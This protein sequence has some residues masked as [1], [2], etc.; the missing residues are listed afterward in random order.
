MKTTF[1]KI[2]ALLCFILLDVNLYGQAQQ[3]GRAS[4]TGINEK[5]SIKIV[6][7]SSSLATQLLFSG[8]GIALFKDAHPT[9]EEAQAA[10]ACKPASGVS[11]SRCGT[12]TVPAN[13]PYSRLGRGGW[14]YYNYT[15]ET[16]QCLPGSWTGTLRDSTGNLI[17]EPWYVAP[18]KTYNYCLSVT[19]S[20][21]ACTATSFCLNPYAV[22][23]KYDLEHYYKKDNTTKF[24]HKLP[25]NSLLFSRDYMAVSA[26]GSNVSEFRIT[27][28]P[29]QNSLNWKLRIKEDP[30]GANA[31]KYGTFAFVSNMTAGIKFNYTHPTIPPSATNKPYEEY[32]IELI[33]AANANIVVKVFKIRVYRAPLLMVHGLNSGPSSFDTMYINFSN[34]NLYIKDNMLKVDYEGENEYTFTANNSV[35]P[36]A[37]EEIT[38]NMLKMKIAVK[39]VD[40]VG[41]SMGGILSRLYHQSSTYKS[42]VNRIITICTPHAG[43][44]LGDLINDPNFPGYS[45]GAVCWWLDC[46]EAI[47]NLRVG[48]AEQNTVIDT[49]LNGATRLSNPVPSHAIITTQTLA[50][51]SKDMKRIWKYLGTTPN[52][53]FGEASDLIVPLSSQQGGLLNNYITS[54]EGQE[55]AGAHANINIINRVAALLAM[56]PNVSLFNKSGFN[57]PNLIYTPLPPSL[58]STLMATSPPPVIIINPLN[59]KTINRNS[60]INISATCQ[61]APKMFL[62]VKRTKNDVLSYEVNASAISIN[63]SIDASFPIGEHKFLVE[64]EFA[65]GQFS[66]AEGKFTVTNCVDNYNPLVGEITNPYYQAKNKIVASGQLVFGQPV[67]MTAGQSIEFKPGFVADT[68]TTLEAKIKACDN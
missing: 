18:G 41:H 63:I 17:P 11:T 19:L 53:L 31:A 12:F 1:F 54:I 43:S 46:D 60:Q 33:D 22:E 23:V 37:I 65:D 64:A 52:A 14:L 39:K 48:A 38:G 44:H 36:D 10:N 55:H 28:Q 34:K 62:Y 5:D 3:P 29:A 27:G 49:G 4:V 40:L 7:E 24:L 68:Y 16:N 35:I 21:G 30:T 61:Q 51:G 56:D 20:N 57:P 26:D 42:D 25:D 50:N 66:Y 47:D 15:S 13:Q 32:N 58:Q 6:K 9:A 59:N 8:D 67:V 45:R 2:L